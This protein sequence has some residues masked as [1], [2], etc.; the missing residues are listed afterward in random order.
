MW[1]EFHVDVVAINAIE[2][3]VV[4]LNTIVLDVVADA[5]AEVI[6]CC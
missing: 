4:G 6:Y 3:D 2:L 1:V 5:A